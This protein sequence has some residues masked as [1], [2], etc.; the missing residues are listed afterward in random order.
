MKN[1]VR[2]YPINGAATM[3]HAAVHIAQVGRKVPTHILYQTS[4]FYGR[5]H[6]VTLQ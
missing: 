4:Q 3:G 5:Q 2:L 6:K 1:P